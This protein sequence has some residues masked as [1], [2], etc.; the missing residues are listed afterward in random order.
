[1]TTWNAG[2]WVF[3]YDDEDEYWYP[4]TIIRI[5]GGDFTVRWDYDDSESIVDVDSLDAYSTF[6][7]EKNAE[8]YWDDDESYYAVVIKQVDKENVLVEY[9][10]GTTEWKDLS[11]LRFG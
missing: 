6:P 9:E 3:A 11:N 5:R 10:D 7:G 8:C 4:A 2:D 1:M